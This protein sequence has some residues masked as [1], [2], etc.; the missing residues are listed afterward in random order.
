MFNELCME[1]G[2]GLLQKVLVLRAGKQHLLT[3]ID[4][5]PVCQT[6]VLTNM[7]LEAGVMEFRRCV[8]RALY[9]ACADSF[10]TGSFFKICGIRRV[11]CFHASSIV[12]TQE[13]FFYFFFSIS[14]AEIGLFPDH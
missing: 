11:I 13:R 7:P 6:P 1:R 2:W 8:F 10:A 12:S 14:S 5:Y 9:G 3:P 4:P